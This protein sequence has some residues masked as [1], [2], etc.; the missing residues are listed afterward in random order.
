MYKVSDVIQQTFI[1]YFRKIGPLAL[2][3]L[4]VAVIEYIIIA[5]LPRGDV[6]A[7]INI[8]ELIVT[9][10]CYPLLCAPALKI[11]YNE[12]TGSRSTARELASF[13]LQKWIPLLVAGIM[14]GFIVL[15]ASLLIFPGI[16]FAV[17]YAFISCVVCFEDNLSTSARKRSYLITKEKFKT[18]LFTMALFFPL[19]L[20]LSLIFS[21]TGGFSADGAAAHLFGILPLALS[22]LAEILAECALLTLYL[23]HREQKD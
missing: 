23:I 21:M 20:A 6:Y 16:F 9:A 12:K 15:L 18:I 17:R 3:A 13:A 11:L 1:L 4:I 22:N 14:A 19:S 7:E 5:L 8:T 2:T 10:L